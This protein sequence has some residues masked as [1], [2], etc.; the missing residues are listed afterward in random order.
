VQAPSKA[1]AEAAVPYPALFPLADLVRLVRLV[2]TFFQTAAMDTERQDDQIIPRKFDHPDKTKDL[3]GIGKSQRVLS[4]GAGV[5]GAGVVSWI[6]T[7]PACLI[8]NL[9]CEETQSD[10][11]YFKHHRPRGRTIAMVGIRKV[12]SSRHPDRPHFSAWRGDGAP[13]LL[14]RWV[15]RPARRT[16]ALAGSPAFLA[17]GNSKPRALHTNPARRI[18]GGQSAMPH[19]AACLHR[20]PMANAASLPRFQA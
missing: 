15:G 1:G 4:T 20:L 14:S 18:M 7:K 8:L 13:P 11:A 3:A 6:R 9:R 2:R 5:A 10:G 19:I 17:R 16:E 12:P